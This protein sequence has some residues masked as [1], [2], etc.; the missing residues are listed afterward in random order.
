MKKILVLLLVYFSFIVGFFL[1]GYI[2]SDKQVTPTSSPTIIS[3]QVKFKVT[4]VLDG[5]TIIIE[6]GEKVRYLGI[7]APEP[8]DA[9]GIS[10]SKYNE[11]LVLGKEV[12]LEYDY[13]RFDKYGRNLAYVWVDQV[14]VNEKMVEEGFAKVYTIPG[15]NKLKYIDR[16]NTAQQWAKDHHNGIWLEEWRNDIIAP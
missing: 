13:E 12:K 2:N 14:L 9:Y 4:K 16:L 5:D 1:R 8:N 15:T 11:G 10:A 6:T 7:D 3:T